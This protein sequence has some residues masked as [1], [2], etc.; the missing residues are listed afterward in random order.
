M[1]GKEESAKKAVAAE[2]TE[3]LFRNAGI[4][5]KYTFVIFEDIPA[6]DWAIGGQLWAEKPQAS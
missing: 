6:S 2:I 4:E 1:Q 3:S 5:P